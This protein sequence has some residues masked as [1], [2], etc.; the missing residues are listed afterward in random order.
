LDEIEV[1]TSYL[2]QRSFQAAYC[3]LLLKVT[4]ENQEEALTEF[5]RTGEFGPYSGLS[6]SGIDDLSFLTRFPMLL[7]LEVSGQSP[8]N[9][10]YL[11]GLQNLRGLYLE[12]PGTG[13]DFAWFPLLEVYFGGWHPASQNLAACQ[14][15]R[16]LE[17]RGFNPDSRGLEAIAR[18]TRLEVLKVV[19][20]NLESLRG[21]ETLE[22]LRYLSL[23]YAAKLSS[24][25][26]LTS[27]GTGLREL[28]LQNL[29]KI[30]FYE[31][32]S[33][34]RMLRRLRLTAC[35]PMESL[36]WTAGL[37]NLDFFSFV[38]TVVENGDLA[39]LL[40]LPKLRYA[41]TLDKKHYN[42]KC[43]DLNAALSEARH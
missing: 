14:E 34:L 12:A 38:D 9:A 13:I 2:T 33:S 31:P 28:S 3:D 1:R 5:G 17:L 21:L 35:A 37:E 11:D 39:P 30:A 20:T 8:I 15:L 7:Y 19:Q 41:G 27:C 6:V 32:I 25:D 43:A 4:P 10:R 24:L 29:K 40:Q 26:V 16:R 22:D 36:A 18:L 42:Y 23:A